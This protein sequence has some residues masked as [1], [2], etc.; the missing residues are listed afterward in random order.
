MAPNFSFSSLRTRHWL[1]VLAIVVGLV[2]L[3]LFG[4]RMWHQYQ[5]A[6]RVAA[7]EIQVE[8][9]RGWMTLSYI[10]RVYGIQ[11]LALR[12]GLGLPATGDEERSLQS[13]FDLRG[14]DP[15]TGRAAVEALILAEVTRRG[16]RRD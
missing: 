15:V 11:E 12:E 7:G 8:S 5:Y 4:M 1:G 3:S 2:L 13:W 16:A 6:Q 10:S 9:L 14:I